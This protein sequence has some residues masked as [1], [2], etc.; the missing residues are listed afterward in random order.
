MK[1][2]I[3]FKSRFYLLGTILSLCISL[4]L[5]G[6]TTK[7]TQSILSDTRFM[8]N[9]VVTISLYDSSD[10][11]IL[12]GAFDLCQDYEDLLSRTKEGS[13]IYTFNNR[14]NNA[15]ITVSDDTAELIE[16][17]LYYCELSDGAFDITIAP[18]SSLWDFQADTPT[19]P[20][21]EII[22]EQVQSVN[23][24]NLQLEGN[25][26]SSS[27]PKTQIDLGAIAKGFIADK[28]KEYLLSKGVKSAVI[29]LGGNVLC[30][31]EKP[32]NEAFQIGIQKPFETHQETVG[33]LAIRDLSIVSSGIYERYF[34]VDG[35]LYHHILNPRTGYPYESDLTSVTILSKKSVDGDGLSTTCFSLGLEKGMELIE[36]LDDVYALFI[37]SDGALHYTEGF[38]D[39]IVNE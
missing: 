36:S 33:T 19:V 34:K 10:S 2:Q 3:F 8:L 1:I 38:K 13:E 9:T 27:N 22:K 21:S 17:A 7:K 23:Y 32:S 28:I 11:S 31:G 12:D 15:P 6:C 4:L 20:D 16:K 25:I 29:N 5:T 37:T 14:K 35:K 26:L 24:K 18:I 39:F 30:V